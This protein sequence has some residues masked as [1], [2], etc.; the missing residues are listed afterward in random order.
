MLP[1]FRPGQ[2]QAF[3]RATSEYGSAYRRAG[4][5]QRSGMTLEQCGSAL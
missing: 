2:L 4:V 1:S 3:A 5:G